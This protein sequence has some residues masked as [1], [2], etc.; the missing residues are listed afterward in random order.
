MSAPTTRLRHWVDRSLASRGQPSLD[1]IVDRC[2]ARGDSWL[3]V[4]TEVTA[5]SGES[6]SIQTLINWYG[7]PE[8]IEDGA[9]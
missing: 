2:R 9:S 5:L 1:E 6:I 7:E 8:P 3:A 4:A